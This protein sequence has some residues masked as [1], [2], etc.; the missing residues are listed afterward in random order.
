MPKAAE[1][2]NDVALKADLGPKIFDVAGK[3]VLVTGGGSGIGAM[4]ASA[5]VQN[6]ACVVIASRKDTQAFAAAL[7]AKGPGKC[8]AL[9]ADVAS[10]ADCGK[11]KE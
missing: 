10:E 6:G 11:I 7:S 4:I 2:E 5:F 9:R 3:V 8:E 1:G